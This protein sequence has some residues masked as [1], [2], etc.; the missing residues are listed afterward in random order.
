MKVMEKII[1]M[2]IE[3]INEA[4]VVALATELPALTTLHLYFDSKVEKP[5]TIDGLTKIVEN[6]KKLTYIAL[7]DVQYLTIDQRAFENLQKVAENRRG[8]NGEKLVVNQSSA[9][10]KRPASMNRP[11]CKKRAVHFWRSNT[12]RIVMMMMMT[13]IIETEQR[14]SGEKSEMTRQQKH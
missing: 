5:I 12:L 3:Q 8:E 14:N 7:V 6:R 4:E 1:L 2:A 10:R 13:M 9:I 11:L